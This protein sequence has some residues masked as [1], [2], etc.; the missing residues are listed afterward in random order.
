MLEILKQ[1]K[2]QIEIY[3]AALVDL[4]GEFDA[5]QDNHVM[6]QIRIANDIALVCAK[7][8]AVK[9]LYKICGGV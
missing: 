4:R 6:L 8:D 2:T 9:H 1:I 3:E 7:L 5:A